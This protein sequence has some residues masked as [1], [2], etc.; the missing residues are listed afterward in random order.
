MPYKINDSLTIN[1]I[2][3][4]GDIQIEIDINGQYDYFYLNK[5]KIKEII[6]FLQSQIDED[7]TI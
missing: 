5:E 4:D 6:H 2:D 3:K 1:E 7:R